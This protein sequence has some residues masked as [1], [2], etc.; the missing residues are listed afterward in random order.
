MTE[1][2]LNAVL[3]NA[4]QY[5]ELIAVTLETSR[6]PSDRLAVML[7]AREFVQWLTEQKCRLHAH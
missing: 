3:D 6:Q 7:A 5:A 2:N 4:V 1:A